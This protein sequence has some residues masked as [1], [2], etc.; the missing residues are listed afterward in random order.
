MTTEVFI[1]EVR[2][3]GTKKAAGD[4]RQIG[5]AA[6]SVR[7]TLAF[8]RAALVAVAAVRVFSTLTSDIVAFSDEMLVV[9]AVRENYLVATVQTDVPQVIVFEISVHKQR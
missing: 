1:L 8:L 5:A 4:V 9:K 6:S 2:T 7:K 3:R